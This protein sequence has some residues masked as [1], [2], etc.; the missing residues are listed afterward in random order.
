M[1]IH[2]DNLEDIVLSEIRQTEKDRCFA[3]S[4]VCGI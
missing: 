4:L 3:I 2:M 1:G